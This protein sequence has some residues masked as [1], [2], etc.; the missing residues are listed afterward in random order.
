MFITPILAIDLF[1]QDDMKTFSKIR[2]GQTE[3]QNLQLAAM[4][5]NRML[6]YAQMKWDN[7]AQAVKTEKV[8]EDTLADIENSDGQEYSA[9]DIAETAHVQLG[10]DIFSAPLVNHG[11]EEPK[12]YEYSVHLHN[13]DYDVQD[14]AYADADIHTMEE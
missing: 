13:K 6:S 8:D 14:V 9:K 11:L 3:E 2:E 5:N 4:T 12:I 7:L 1:L 10:A